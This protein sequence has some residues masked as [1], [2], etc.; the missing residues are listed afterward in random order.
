MEDEDYFEKE[1]NGEPGQPE[2]QNAKTIEPT[3][4]ENSSE[5]KKEE[6]KENAMISE[7]SECEQQGD[8]LSVD[9]NADHLQEN[10]SSPKDR[11][12][13]I[14]NKIQTK[15]KEDEEGKAPNFNKSRS[16]SVDRLNNTIKIQL[17]INSA[18]NSGESG[19][20]SLPLDKRRASE[21]MNSDIEQFTTEPQKKVKLWA[22]AKL[23]SCSINNHKLGNHTDFIPRT[24]VHV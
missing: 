21:D 2:K 23:A 22:P 12:A 17:K 6:D 1:E 18:E 5:E 3:A 14:R 15:M 9:V 13:N 20:E 19:D 11:I 8:K 4:I 10:L 24:V 16:N 7:K